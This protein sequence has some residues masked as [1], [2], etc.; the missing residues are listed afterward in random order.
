MIFD[1]VLILPLSYQKNK[2]ILRDFSENDKLKRNS[3]YLKTGNKKTKSKKAAKKPPIVPKNPLFAQISLKDNVKY[4]CRL[5]N[6]LTN[7]EVKTQLA[8]MLCQRIKTNSFVVHKNVKTPHISA[9][10][11]YEKVVYDAVRRDTKAPPKNQ[12]ST[13]QQHDA[14]KRKSVLSRSEMQLLNVLIP[15]EKRKENT[16]KILHNTEDLSEDICKKEL[17]E[18]TYNDWYE[19]K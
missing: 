15:K 14:M 9:M 11:V 5:N 2:S 13:I 1:K 12:D 4:W 8:F 7:D 3:L 16:K 10:D 17:G 6:H 18:S 19:V